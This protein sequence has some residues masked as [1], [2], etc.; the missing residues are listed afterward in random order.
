MI[1]NKNDPKRALKVVKYLNYDF[2]REPKRYD[3]ESSGEKFSM[4]EGY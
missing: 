1:D 4:I 2:R 3:C